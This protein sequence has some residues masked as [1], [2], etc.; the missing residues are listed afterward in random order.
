MTSIT[1]ACIAA[2]AAS[3]LTVPAFAQHKHHDMRTAG[4]ADPETHPFADPS[5]GRDGYS[6]AKE[7]INEFRLYDFYQRQ[8]DHF[9]KQKPTK[10]LPAYPGLDAGMHG[11]WG[12]FSQNQHNDDWWNRQR[13]NNMQ[14]GRLIVDKVKV[15]KAINLS[16]GD[17]GQLGAC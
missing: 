5:Q 1:K 12:K 16:L 7:P 10:F 13:E 11:H 14:G 8:A 6:L 15:E 9:M 4:I 2:L 3:Y 17:D